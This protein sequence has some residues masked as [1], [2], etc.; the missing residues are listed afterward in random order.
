MA[1]LDFPASPT[2]NQTYTDNG[3][4]WQWDGTSW[5][6]QNDSTSV[7]LGP[8]TATDNAIA[9]FDGT[10]GKLVQNSTVTIDDNG[11][12]IADI[13]GNADGLVQGSQYFR[14]NSGLAGANA[15]GAQSMFGVGVTLVGSTVYEFEYLA[16]FSKTA[17]TTSHNFS[18]G[19]GGTATVNN[20]AYEYIQQGNS[21]GNF[22]PQATSSYTGFIQTT[23][24]S[25]I[26]S[27]IAS[28]TVAEWVLVKGTVSINAGG[29]FIPQYSLSAAPG[30][31]YTT[32]AGSYI[33]I[34]PLSAS[35]ANTSIGSWA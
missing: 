21:S 30:G 20:I 29:T 25:A 31:A 15:T 11:F 18:I 1:A 4:T 27:G 12:I 33:K 17:G 19:F 10:S 13:K 26:N 22:N 9:R 34:S 6:A 14:L 8:A 28:A 32:Q 5:N 23:A 35:G 7:V 16:A 2:L 24:A 3:Y